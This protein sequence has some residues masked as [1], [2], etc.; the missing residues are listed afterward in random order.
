MTIKAGQHTGTATFTLSPT[1]DTEEEGD[2]KLTI[3][4]TATRLEVGND[5]EATIEDDDQPIIVLT[6]SP[7]NIPE[8]KTGRT[9]TVTVTAS[10]WTGIDRCAT[11]AVAE[12]RGFTA[13]SVGASAEQAAR[14]VLGAG[15]RAA[16]ASSD[17]TVAVTIGDTGD[18]AVSGT[19]YTAVTGFNVTIKDGE[20]KGTATF[21]TRGVLDSILEP[22]E[23]LTVKGALTGKTV[24]PA[25]GQVDDK[26]K[27]SPTLTVSPTSVAEDA[28]ATTVTV[29]MNT[30]GVTA[31]ESFEVPFKVTSGTA[32]AGTDF[33]KVN[34]FNGLLG[35]GDTSLTATFTLTPTD[36]TVVEGDETIKVSI[37]G[38]KPALEATV[39]LT[40]DD[41]TDITLSGSPTTVA[42]GGTATS[43]TVTAATDGDTF[44]SDR[45]V[46][47]SV[48][49]SGT[50]TSGTDYAAVADIDITIKAGLTSAT[51]DFTLTPTQDT[52]VEGDETVGVDGTSTGETVNGTDV[53]IT[54]DD[55]TDITLR[56]SPSSVAENG[57]AT[58][59]T[60]TA[61]TDGD[62]FSADR[63]VTVSVGGSTDSAA[64]GTDYTAVADFDVTITAGNTSGSADFTLPPT[65]DTIIE[66]DETITVSGSATGLTVNDP[67]PITLTD[68]D[69][70]D[71]T[72]S[73]NLASVSEGASATT[74]TVTAASDGDTFKTART[75][76][77]TV[78]KSGDGATSGTDYAAV[79]G[80][81]VTIPAGGAS[82]S[83]AFTL[84][85][86]ADSVAE[87]D[88]SISLQGTATGLTVIDGSMTL[89][90]DD[91]GAITLT[92]SPD[93]I[94]EGA[95]ATT[96][97]VTAATNAQTYPA[98]RKVRVT[99]G[100]SGDGAT[101]GTDYAAVTAFDITIA[102]GDT[103]GTGTFSLTP[104]EDRIIEGDESI[105]VDGTSTGVTVHADTVT[106]TD[107]DSTAISITLSDPQDVT[108][109]SV[110]EGGE[111]TTV[112]V[113]AA[114]DGDTFK[115][116]RTVTVSVGASGDSATAGTDYAA[117]ADLDIVISAG[118]TSG[119]G[120]FIF[121]PKQD[122]LVE[123][124]ETAAVSGTSTGLTVNGTTATIDDDDSVPSV[125]LS[126]NP[127]S[128]SEGASGTTVTVTAKFSN[129]STYT[130]AKTVAVTV[131]ASG[132]SATSGTDYAAV[133]G[134]DVTISA[135]N[136]SGVATFT[137]TPTD[138]TLVEGDESISVDGSSSELSVHRREHD[139]G[140]RRGR[141]GGESLRQPVERRGNRGRD[142]GDG[143]G[144]V[145]QHQYLR[146]G[147]DGHGLRGRQR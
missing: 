118:D 21:T 16:S 20:T 147:P 110:P 52:V 48:G 133:T 82:G 74:V 43:V 85:P 145:L 86:T 39:T 56:V 78:G 19:D 79:T 64:S 126:T 132:D 146:R 8:Q 25:K 53:S 14:A 115:T 26:D 36:D 55:S 4:G 144:R 2:E 89:A 104:T 51:A 124:N 28:S 7:S 12:A 125:N 70:T 17:Q 68:D 113:T 38:A 100:A 96:V 141:A 60:V 122:T 120:T 15:A 6:M 76:S 95:S 143:N 59:V 91:D 27:T 9:T 127:T 101:S 142:H 44:A 87:G 50:A 13:S 49:D 67:G 62:T 123:G 108:P 11:D 69:S 135:G 37:P 111:A 33:A 45:T 32:T 90:D 121:T 97:T 1:D 24:T 80:F 92:A 30:G 75:V 136:S 57:G 47:V 63:T 106:L 129:S 23:T 22:P 42:E 107:D 114:T 5:V 46:T 3:E 10:Q 137:L 71:I 134:F 117:V 18:T 83:A 102:K 138:D 41:E 103:S 130:S 88:E 109:V 140:R 94:A 112:T 54:D 73:A 98:D 128:V 66:G 58:T 93:S 139:A 65:Q 40:E 77:V 105:T 31:S 81:D 34:D 116:D 99:V 119:S 72:L 131:G 84:T 35:A 29:T 61:V